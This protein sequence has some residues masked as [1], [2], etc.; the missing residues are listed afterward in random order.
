[1]SLVR[2]IA[3]PAGEAREAGI[4]PSAPGERHPRRQSRTRLLLGLILAAGL[5]L[6]C[7]VLSLGVGAAQIPARVVVEALVDFDGSVE[8]LTVRTLRLPRAL[9]AATVGG[10]LAVAGALM[11]GVTRNPLA[12]PSLLGINAGAA[13]AVVAA[14]SLAGPLS[15]GGAAVLAF[16]GAG[17]TV[18]IVYLLGSTGRGGLATVRVVIAGAA[19]GALFSSLTTAILIFDGQALEQIRFWIAGSVAGRDLALLVDLLPFLLAGFAVA[20]VLGK[21][22]TTLALGESIA[23]GLGQRTLRVRVAAALAVLLLAGGS[24]AVAGPIAFI[25]LVVPNA[26]RPLIGVDYRWILPYSAVGGALL[27]LA[28]DVAARLIIRPVELPVG[29][30]TAVIGGPVL[31]YLARQEVAQ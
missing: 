25:G 20:L 10:A 19:L 8:H 3:G 17:L 14:S 29:V 15:T 26:V 27:L 21:Q 5:L 16:A 6:L 24:V 30:M 1:M 13:L 12:S 9:V 22:I 2:S 23:V 28:A 4:A 18:V 11:Q 31:I 7:L